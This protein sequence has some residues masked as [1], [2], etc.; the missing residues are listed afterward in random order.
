MEKPVKIGRPENP[1]ATFA[2]SLGITKRAAAKI[3][4][5]RLR[6]M[7]PDALKV[8]VNDHAR[9]RQRIAERMSA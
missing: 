2:R 1:T 4:Y 6:A 3:G 9:N 5:D 7:S 8:L